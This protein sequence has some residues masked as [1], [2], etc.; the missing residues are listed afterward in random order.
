MDSC[1]KEWNPYQKLTTIE[2]KFAQKVCR[3]LFA[4]F[5]EVGAGFY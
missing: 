1:L 5:W 3:K 4:N 2:T